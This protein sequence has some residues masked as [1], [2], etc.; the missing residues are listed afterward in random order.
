MILN[1]LIV[2]KFYTSILVFFLLILSFSSF[3]QIDAVDDAP[4]T[5]TSSNAALLIS[6]YILDNDT[7]NGNLVTNTNTN[8]TPVSSGPLSINADGHILLASNTTSGTYTITY[9]LCEADTNTG[10]N[11]VPANCDTATLTIIVSNVIDANDDVYQVSNATTT[12]IGN[13]IN[14]DTFNGVAAVSSITNVTP[15]TNG[16]LSINANGVLTIT[17]NTSPGTYTITYQLCEEGAVPA[18]CALASVTVN[19]AG[20]TSIITAIDDSFVFNSLGGITASVLNN[21]TINGVPVIPNVGV[22][23]AIYTTAVSI[24][25]GCIFNPDGTIS[26]S[27]NLPSGTYPVVYQICEM[28]NPTNCDTAVVTIV[29][30]NQLS[31]DM[32]GTYNDYNNDGFVNVGDV[33]NYQITV[34]NNGTTTMTN[35]TACQFSMTVN[36]G[37]LASLNAGAS[38]STF[39]TGVHVITQAEI[40]AGNVFGVICICAGS[41]EQN[42]LDGITTPLSQSNGI[43]LQAFI[44]SNSNGIKDGSEIFFSGGNFNYSINGGAP[45]NLYSNTGINYLYES[46]PTNTYNLSYTVPNTNYSC[47]TTYTNI[48]VPNGSGITT[49]NFPVTIVSYH[50]L[51][52]YLS[53]YG[54]PRPGFNYQNLIQINNNGN[55]TITSGTITFTKDNVLSISTPPSG[56]TATAAGFTYNFTNLLPFEVR[57][58]L[59]TFQVPTIPTVSLGQLITN[60]V[61]V[62]IPSGDINVNNN[63]SSLT[64]TILGSYDPNDKHESHGG[65]ILHSTFT[66][67]DYLTYTIRFENTGTAEAINVSVND[68]LDSKLNP[69]TIKMIAASH[70]YVLQRTG[71]ELNWKFDGINLPPSVPNTQIGHGYI[72]FQIKPTAGY[73]IGDVIPNFAN[74]YFDFNPA[75]VTDVCNTEFVATL[76]NQNFAFNNLNYYPNPVKNSLTISNSSTIDEVEIT[77]ILGQKMLSK[78]VNDLQ[79]EINL[80]EL[81]NGIYFVKVSS[82]GQEKTFKIIKE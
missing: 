70:P 72:T 9:Q 73:A 15:T 69:N 60:S 8:V 34:T 42:C 19:V 3:G 51:A 26:V 74:I 68:V 50:D 28:L 7:L 40:N 17:P 32:V 33:I 29:I 24:P 27:P 39:F 63:N 47:S 4:I 71:T 55:Q 57:H 6:S 65:K 14:N 16:V 21:D 82:E 25:A 45:T 54:V 41:G 5:T 18:N 64:Q 12:T 81:S 36:G 61:S 77:S 53:P 38:N 66:S 58:I 80:S 52:V 1:Y 13:V 35:L 23:N 37:T 11:V 62:T 22:P 44:D 43:K 49:Y 75:I 2:R 78:K 20:P 67:N 46:N 48:T 56:A 10:L 79:A 59:V 30:T 76:S 31:I